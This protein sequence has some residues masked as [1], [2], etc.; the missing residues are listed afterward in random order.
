MYLGVRGVGGREAVLGMYCKR[1][2]S[3]DSEFE[4]N[5]ARPQN[6]KEVYV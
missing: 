5:L 1:E 3:E 6:Y 2:D 4:T